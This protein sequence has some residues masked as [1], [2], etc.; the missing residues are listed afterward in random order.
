MTNARKKNFSEG[1]KLWLA[2]Q[3][4][5]VVAVGLVCL[6]DSV[7]VWLPVVVIDG[8]FW[9]SRVASTAWRT[10]SWVALWF[11]GFYGINSIHL[12]FKTRRFIGR[13]HKTI[14]VAM[15]RLAAISRHYMLLRGG[16]ALITFLG[17]FGVMLY[18]VSIAFKKTFLGLCVFFSGQIL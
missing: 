6:C 12:F 3:L 4:V 8:G 9:V 5:W 13:R 10:S 15:E 16:R 18:T 11:A 14:S 2:L 7:M 1:G 17:A